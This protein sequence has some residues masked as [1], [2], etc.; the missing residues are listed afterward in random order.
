MREAGRH[1]EVR[2]ETTLSVQS[3]A[4]EWLVEEVWMRRKL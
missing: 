1:A 3:Y 2:L 4:V